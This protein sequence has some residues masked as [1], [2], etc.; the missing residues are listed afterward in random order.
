MDYLLNVHRKPQGFRKHKIDVEV[1]RQDIIDYP[2]AHQY[3]RAKR[4][5]VSEDAIFLGLKKHG[6]TYTKL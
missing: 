2:D 5:G 6:V 1:L 4:L 3:E